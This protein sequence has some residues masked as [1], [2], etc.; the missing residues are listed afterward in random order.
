VLPL[1]RSESAA[2]TAVIFNPAPVS[3]VKC[4]DR[5]CLSQ[6]NYAVESDTQGPALRACARAAHRQR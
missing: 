4:E 2:Y 3:A 5:A 1:A 6:P